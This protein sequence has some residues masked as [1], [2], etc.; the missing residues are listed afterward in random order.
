MK[1][2][3][4]FLVTIIFK[5]IFFLSKSICLLNSLTIT[6]LLVWE[7]EVLSLKKSVMETPVAILLFYRYYSEIN[8]LLPRS[9]HQEH[10]PK[11]LSV[12]YTCRLEHLSTV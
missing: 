4:L 6:L 2:C 10:L 12:D 8:C 5:P 1:M 3:F 11:F 9:S 7:L